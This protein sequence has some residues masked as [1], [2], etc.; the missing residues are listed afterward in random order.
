MDESENIMNSTSREVKGAGAPR[1]MRMADLE[2]VGHVK[3]A[4]SA[5]VGTIDLPIR[6]LFSMKQG[7]VLMLNERVDAPVDL[8]LDGRLV[9]RGELL[10]VDDHFG[11]RILELA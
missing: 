8:L 4:L 7:D 10:A 6:E 2:L 5:R 3:V 11:I 9:A 1:E